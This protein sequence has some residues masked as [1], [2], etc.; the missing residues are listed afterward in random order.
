MREGKLFS[1]TVLLGAASALSKVISFVML[2]LYTAALTPAEFGVADVLVSTAVLLLPIVSLHAPEAVF[3]F[4][5]GG[6]QGTVSVGG[7]FLLLGLAVFAACLPLIGLS[8]RLRPYVWLLYAYVAASVLRSFLAHVLRS[9]GAF[10]LYA[11]QQLFCTLLTVSFQY[12]LLVVY[13]QGIRGYLLAVI[14]ADAITFT[15]LFLT[16]YAH[17]R[18][19]GAIR[20]PLCKKMAKFA[21]P[22]I[23]NTVLWWVM[24]LSDRYLILVYGGEAQAGL[25]AAAARLPS[26]VT[27]AMSVF[28]ESWHYTAIRAEKGEEGRLFGRIYGMLLPAML[29]LGAM[30]TLAAPLLTSLLLAADYAAAVHL[31]P[32]LTLGAL[33]GAFAN[34]LGSVYT[35]TL[36]S[37]SALLTGGIAAAGNVALNFL[38]I[39]RYGAGGAALST[40]LSCIAYFF[41]RLWHTGRLLAFT[42]HWAAGLSAIALAFGSA[43]F[44]LRGEMRLGAVFTL[45]ALLPV[46]PLGLSLARFL[47]RRGKIL[48][49]SLKKREK[50]G[51]KV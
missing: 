4:R 24:S 31:V 37:G 43:V 45:L 11:I 20:A 22:L 21:L 12:L 28:L 41:L 25:Y 36:R 26:L 34:F 23:P 47:Y 3:R 50:N 2:P 42:R 29:L 5:A 46:A 33:C 7:S 16:Q 27:L 14:L 19:D 1:N 39:P 44:F 30:L 13:R 49:K 38:L 51:K 40:A 18:P 10:V 17:F 6:E 35:L 48:L 15:V 9:D 8:E 32:L